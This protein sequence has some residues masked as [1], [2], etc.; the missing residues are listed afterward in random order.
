VCEIAGPAESV[1]KL[2]RHR[3]RD[4]P[5][6]CLKSISRMSVYSVYVKDTVGEF[7]RSRW[8]SMVFLASGYSSVAG[9]D[10][11]F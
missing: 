10:V 6:R 11:S 4:G 8:R 9:T 3:T 1:S 2:K 7:S 5:I